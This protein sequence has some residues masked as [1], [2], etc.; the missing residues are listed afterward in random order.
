MNL[1]KIP[2][3]HSQSMD[4]EFYYK[5][6]QHNQNLR[7]FL[8]TNKEKVNKKNTLL[9]LKEERSVAAEK[10]LQDKLISMSIRPAVKGDEGQSFAEKRILPFFS[11][12]VILKKISDKKK[13]KN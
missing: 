10:K 9:K 7:L 4:Q 5:N 13:Y 2:L 8:N 6:L 11:V 3:L 1:K 12:P